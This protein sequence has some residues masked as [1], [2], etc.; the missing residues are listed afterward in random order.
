M[1]HADLYFGNINVVEA[2]GSNWIKSFENFDKM[3]LASFSL[4]S[5]YF[6]QKK[7]V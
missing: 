5:G 1:S 6:L 4:P 2:N 3:T 7:S